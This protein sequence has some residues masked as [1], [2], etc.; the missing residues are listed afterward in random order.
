MYLDINKKIYFSLIVMS[1]NIIKNKP[2][3]ITDYTYEQARKIGVKIEP[4][5]YKNKKIDVY[6]KDN[7][8]IT[9]IGFK[10]MNDYPTYIEAKGREYADERRRLFYKRFNNIK[11]NSTLY[12]SSKL[13]W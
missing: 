3:K 12:Y 8:Y 2:Y 1:D 7:N 5:K 6:D 9:S 11:K 13:L 4:S 10:G